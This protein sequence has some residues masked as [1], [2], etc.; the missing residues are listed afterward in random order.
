MKLLLRAWNSPTLMS[1]GSMGARLMGLVVLLPLVLHR[2]SPPDIVLWLLFGTIVTLQILADAGFSQTF[3]R[4]IACAEGGATVDV[5]R[6]LRAAPARRDDAQPNLDTLVR[7]LG[8]MRRVYGRLTL[9]SLLI[10]VV[11]GPF[12]LSTPV[13]ASTDPRAG[14]LAAILVLLATA[15][16]LWGNLYTAYLQGRDRIALLRRWEMLTAIAGVG[17]SIVVLLLGGELLAVV[18]GQQAWAIVS[19]MRNRWLCRQDAVFRDGV[20]STLDRDVLSAVWPAAW[21]SG[22]GVFMSYGL[23]QMSGI[24]YA[25]MGKSTEVAAYLLALRMIQTISMFS[26]APFYSKLP[27]LARLRSQGR[28]EE[29]TQLAKQGMKYSHWTFLLGFLLV[30]GSSDWLLQLI[31]SQ[32]AFV[33]LPMWTLLGLAF[34]VERLGAMHIQLYSTT[35]K[36]IWHI[37]NGLTGL[38]MLAG[39]YVAYPHYGMLA[40]PLAMLASYALIYCT[41]SL[42]HSYR[43][44]GLTVR[45]FELEASVLPFAGAALCWLAFLLVGSGFSAR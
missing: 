36:I 22:I 30:G 40:F 38:A 15:V 18:A 13:G 19:V 2:F 24:A 12:V 25:Q 39:F 27:A 21:R 29:Q 42:W 44:F 26:Q 5:L 45:S 7:L 37:A 31:H 34:F 14:W 20:S 33:S 4:S 11:G 41:I 10:M 35:N 1:W 8:T 43:A 16:S 32:S 28:V 17:T 3:A 9:L 6:D 23:I